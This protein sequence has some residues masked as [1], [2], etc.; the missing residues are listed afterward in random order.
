MTV[1]DADFIGELQC[2]D[3]ARLRER[4]AQRDDAFK[5]FVVVVRRVGA[6]RRVEAD[7]LVEDRVVG[8]GTFVDD[9]GVDVGLEGRAD[10]AHG[11]RGAVEFGFVEVASADQ[12]LDAAGGVVDG[13]Q[14]ALSAGVLLEADACR[15]V[16]AERKN[17]DVADVA[18]LENVRELLLRP[19][20]VGLTE[21][22]GVAAELQRS[23]SGAGGGDESVDVSVDFGLVIPVRVGIFLEDCSL[24]DDVFEM[25]LPAV[26]ALVGGQAV[27]HGLIR[28]LLHV[29]VE[30]G[31]DLQ[32][33]FVDLVGAVL[34]FE[35]AANFFDEIWSER[36]RDRGRDAGPA[37]PRGLRRPA[38]Q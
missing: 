19:G 27:E 23:D 12:G 2:G 14:R 18:G 20:D 22:G 28:G 11:L 29:D 17:L 5:F 37:G 35:I 1:L 25:T 10:L 3:V 31:V 24:G 8:A 15:A 7:G 34:A 9:R 21:R 13:E 33:A 4:A 6:R 26:A 38:R 36:I 16:R 30:R 32:A